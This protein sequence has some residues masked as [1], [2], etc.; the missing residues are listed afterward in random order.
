MQNATRSPALRI[1]EVVSPDDPHL[2]QAYRLLSKSFARTERVE[3]RDWVASL[4]EKEGDLLTDVVWH[5]FIAVR[6][7]QVVGLASGTFLGN[8][9]VGVIGYLAIGSDAQSLGLGTRLRNRLRSQFERDALQLTGKPLKAIIGEVSVDNP[10]LRR[11]A[12]RP[13]V[14]VLD[15]DYY[16]PRLYEGD[17][18]SPFVLY[19][20][21]LQGVRTRLPVKELRQLLYAIWR[22][23]YR[24]SRPLERP[25]FRAMLRS[26]E[27]RRSVGR[28]NLSRS[29]T[30]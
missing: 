17:A 2:R 18:P 10:W 26:L 19:Y 16:Q 30:R 11:L 6:N 20:E 12:K 4:R 15:F 9:H 29:K 22:R 8:M 27:T 25:S 5:L 3:L 23:V 1:R 13:E 28:L 14:L 7:E 24:L 21:S